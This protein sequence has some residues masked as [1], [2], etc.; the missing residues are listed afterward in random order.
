MT[1]I[2]I[3]TSGG[4]CSGLNAV[5]RAAARVAE[6]DDDLRLVGFRDAWRGVMERD[7]ELMTVERLR[8]TLPRGGTILGTSRVVPHHVEG[9]VE[10]VRQVMEEMELE[11]F[12]VIGGNGSLSAA[13]QLTR[14]GV[15]CVGVP[16]TI[17]NDIVGTDVS[18]GFDT[19]THVATAAIDRLHTTAEAHDRVLVVEVMGRHA[20]HIAVRAGLSGGAAITLIPEVPFDLDEVCEAIVRR[21]EGARWATIVCVAEGAM[22]AEGTLVLPEYEVDRYGHQVLGGICNRIAP[23][24]ERRTGYETRMTILGHVQ[25][26]GTPTAFDRHL[27]TRLG[28]HAVQMVRDGAWGHMAAAR[29]EEIARVPLADMAGKVKTVPREQYEAARLFWP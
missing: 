12:I 22:P 5:I 25:R 4:D 16:K 21:H 3:L 13:E 29:G 23:E 26:G 8:G 6:R 17:D 15:P 18:V 11:G 10:I 20:G 28:I 2:G 1:N 9:G 27:A 7:W 19:A 14:E 24:I